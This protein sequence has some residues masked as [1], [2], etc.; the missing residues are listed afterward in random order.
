MRS[1][2]LFCVVGLLVL[3]A[4]V[5]SAVALEELGFSTHAAVALLVGVFWP[6]GVTMLV[7][8]SME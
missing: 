1:G 3:F 8:D 6:I 2:L 4:G 5:L 7:A